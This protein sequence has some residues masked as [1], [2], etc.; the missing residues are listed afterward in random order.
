[1]KATLSEPQPWKRVLEIEVSTDE[2]TSAFERRLSD[3]RKKLKLPG[4]RPG[5]VPP[6]LV[7]ARYGEA[8]RAEAIEELIQ[9]SYEEACREKAI[10]P[11]SQGKL[12]D[13][14]AEADSPLTFTIETEVEPE[15]E[16]TNYHKLKI[17]PSPNK[18]RPADVNR[19]VQQLRER[20]STFT[21]VERPAAK[22]DFVMLE[23]E[24]VVID[25]TERPDIS[26]PQYPVEV[27]TST[28]KGFDK[29]ITGLHPGEATEATVSFP[30]DYPD[31]E[32]AGKMGAFT[33]KV[34][35]NQERTVPKID[36]EFL[37]KLGEFKD[38]DELRERIRKD[39]EEQEHQRAK[40]EAAS[41]AIETLIKNNPF[42]IPP[43]M[44]ERYI[45]RLYEEAQQRA[46]ADQ[47]PPSRDEIDKRYRE[48]GINAMKRHRIVD[49]IAKKE[50]IKA[51]QAEVDEQIRS[52]ARQYNQPFDVL[53]D[54]FRRNGTTNRIRE[55]IRE[56]KTL[57]FLIGEYE[58]QQQ[59]EQQAT[60]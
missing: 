25:G 13:M 54:A 42:D 52:V 50:N 31:Q 30:K 15:I 14:K 6:Q 17:R 16:I 21:E 33:I 9:T 5:K 37:K 36:E 39:L 46:S 35:K 44:V 34:V 49:Y 43:S 10:T 58:Q 28:F 41:K 4:F 7:K 26:S 40:N 59:Q 3:Y 18:I 51:T 45:D 47:E 53:K 27:G 12:S 1:L 29:A 32:I 48:M 23:Y 2:V 60:S 19:V 56:Q 24:R 55:D 11:V 57:D 22:G 20:N 38:E 8:I